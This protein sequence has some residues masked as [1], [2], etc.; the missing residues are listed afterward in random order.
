MYNDASFCCPVVSSCNLKW[1]YVTMIWL[2][3]V[4]ILQNSASQVNYSKLVVHVYICMS[5]KFCQISN[6]RTRVITAVWSSYMSCLQT[7]AIFWKNVLGKIFLFAIVIL[8]S[9]TFSSHKWSFWNFRVA[10]FNQIAPNSEEAD[11]R[12]SF[13]HMWP[14]SGIL[15]LL[16]CLFAVSC[17]SLFIHLLFVIPSTHLAPDI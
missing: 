15:D 7:F 17:F 12:F 5:E 9:A 3:F 6:H 16:P 14:K 10:P 8:I 4:I 13:L 2:Y 1:N 11:A